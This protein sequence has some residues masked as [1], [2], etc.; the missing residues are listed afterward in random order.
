MKSSNLFTAYSI[1]PI[2]LKL[3]R[4]IVDINPHN[5]GS[6]FFHFLKGGAVGARF[7]QFTKRF[8]AYNSY[9]IE[10]KLGIKILDINLH[11]RHQ[12]DIFGARG[13]AQN[14]SFL[15][16]SFVHVPLSRRRRNLYSISPI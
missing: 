9:A 16:T 6:G 4:M 8:T 7:L 5:L 14:S 2:E 15:Q 10:L 12:Q 1:H 3:C 13:W 11:N